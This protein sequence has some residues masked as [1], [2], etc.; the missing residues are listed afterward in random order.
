MPLSVRNSKEVQK[1]IEDGSALAGM[2]KQDKTDINNSIKGL[3][4]KATGLKAEDRN[5]DVY[6]GAERRIRADLETAFRREVMTGK[7]TKEDGTTDYT[8][9][10]NQAE[11]KIRESIDQGAKDYTKPEA[12]DPRSNS[13]QYQERLRGLTKV[14]RQSPNIFSETN[15]STEQ[16]LSQ[17]QKMVATGQGGFPPMYVDMARGEKNV[18]PY[19]I[20]MAQLNVKG[21]KVNPPAMEDD[22]AAQAPVV[23]EV[24]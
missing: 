7:Y 10:L 11:A 18:T 15:L 23:Q 5:S 22:R 17:A 16:E 13:P 19:D 20:A 6:F 12:Y 8:A 24:L 4:N 14:L 21:Y 2:T 9:A 3:T 1:M